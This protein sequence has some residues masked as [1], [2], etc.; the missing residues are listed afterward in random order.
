MSVDQERGQGLE[1]VRA[2]K[3]QDQILERQGTW[4]FAA[5]L[6]GFY[7]ERDR[8]RRKVQAEA[9]RGLTSAA[10]RSLWALETAVSE[11]RP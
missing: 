3:E 11:D 1:E 5:L 9:R 8:S 4:D 10:K 2:E 7:H 6:A